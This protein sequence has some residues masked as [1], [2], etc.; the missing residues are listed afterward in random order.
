MEVL[1]PD[2]ESSCPRQCFQ[3]CRG[4]FEYQP[5]IH[6]VDRPHL[7][8][9]QLSIAR[10]QG[11]GM[12]K[13]LLFP[14]TPK[15]LRDIWVYSELAVALLQFVFS[16]TSISL[17]KDRAFNIIYLVLASINIVLALIDGFIYFVQLGACADSL[18]RCHSCCKKNHQE[19][20][21]KETKKRKWWQ[22][23]P[24]SVERLNEWFEVF[25]NAGTELLIYPLLVCDLFDLIVGGS[26]QRQNSADSINFSLFVIGGFYLILS[27]YF[28]RIFMTLSSVVTMRR[29]PL[30]YSMAQQNYINLLTR[31]FI[32]VL[33]QIV[34]NAAIIVA[35]GVKIHQENPTPCTTTSGACVN[36]SPFLIYVIVAG[37]IIPFFGVISFFLVNYYQMREFSI[38]FWIDMISLLQ[39]ESF[40][41]LVF[42]GEGVK[43]AKEKT[44][45]FV[46]VVK[47]KEVKDQFKGFVSVSVWV[48]TF[49]PFRIPILVVLGILYELLLLS[50]IVCLLFS[51]DGD[52]ILFE[53]EG[54]SSSFFVVA[55]FLVVANV[56]V[57]LL[58]SF[59]II[60]VTAAVAAVVL[61]P[62]FVLLG[63]MLY[64]PVAGILKCLDYLQ[65]LKYLEQIQNMYNSCIQ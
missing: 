22:L 39:G 6:P 32:H 23:G 8:T 20:D 26:Y 49:Y 19:S 41:D 63:L 64:F 60:V 56:H 2:R 33:F 27:V 37:G 34:T 24:K 45:K 17:S 15:F 51:E 10:N 25:R 13:K 18:R 61:T 1:A 30:D 54:V 53:E 65:I 50:F 47:L 46:E 43:A 28:M 42:Q 12:M 7:L 9:P 3:C 31:F 44:R 57:L 52:F 21:Q 55:C 35:V 29:I 40:A 16:I 48:K 59:W 11:L 38:A 14:A 36:A 62:V 58:V 4:C 5:C